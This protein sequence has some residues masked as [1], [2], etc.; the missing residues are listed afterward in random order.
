[1]YILKEYVD[2]VRALNY[3]NFDLLLVD[4]SPDERYAEHIRSMGVRCERIAW[5]PSAMNRIIASRNVLREKFLDGGYDF[6]LSLE[7][8]VLAPPETIKVLLEHR[9]DFVS[10]LVLN[11]SMVE[12]KRYVV[13]MVSVEFAGRPGVLRYVQGEDIAKGPLIEIKQSHLACTLLSRAV[14]QKFAFRHDSQA[15]DDT[16]L[17]EDMLAA[18]FSLWCDTTLRPVHRPSDWEKIKK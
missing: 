10:T 2:H 13:P 12:G 17:C 3:D 6:F 16:C 5:R 7:Q 1:V 18:G 4:N 8:D 14:L 15:F 11:N 9:K